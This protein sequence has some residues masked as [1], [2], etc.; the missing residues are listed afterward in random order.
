MGGLQFNNTLRVPGLGVNLISEG[1]LHKFGCDVVS[2][3]E[4][5]WR[6][7]IYQNRIIIEAEYEDGL[8]VWRPSTN[9]LL[10]EFL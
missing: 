10:K 2:N 6:K 8:F 3:A 7:V 9:N 5:G 1:V 4:F